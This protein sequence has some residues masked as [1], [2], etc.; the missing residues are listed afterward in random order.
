M[1]DNNEAIAEIAASRISPGWLILDCIDLIDEA[2]SKKAGFVT[3]S[4]RSYA[5]KWLPGCWQDWVPEPKRKRIELL[6]ERLAGYCLDPHHSMYLDGC[7]LVIAINVWGVALRSNPSSDDNLFMQG[8]IRQTRYCIEDFNFVYDALIPR[9]I[10]RD[11]SVLVDGAVSYIRHRLGKQPREVIEE[12]VRAMDD[13]QLFPPGEPERIVAREVARWVDARRPSNPPLQ[14][15]AEA[16]KLINSMM[17][18][19]QSSKAILQA[20]R[21][22]NEEWCDGLPPLSPAEVDVFVAEEIAMLLAAMKAKA[23]K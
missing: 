22:L 13:W 15:R 20:V 6:I 2:K 7:H 3:F 18:E 21:Q 12:S 19:R 10:A 8:V 17:A 16:S 1:S 9:A 4:P 23:N 11:R 14:F 5:M